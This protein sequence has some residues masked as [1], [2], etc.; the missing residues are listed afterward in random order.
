MAEQLENAKDNQSGKQSDSAEPLRN[1]LNSTQT[2]S[3]NGKQLDSIR[4]GSADATQ[5]L[6]TLDLIQSPQGSDQSKLATGTPD[7]TQENKEP[8]QIARD[9]VEAVKNGA[10]LDNVQKEIGQY[11]QRMMSAG[12]SD[13]EIRKNI[14]NLSNE[15][16]AGNTG[17]TDSNG[18]P[19][20]LSVRLSGDSQNGFTVH[21]LS[22][23]LTKNE[24]ELSRF[25]VSHDGSAQN[26]NDQN[27][28]N[29]EPWQISKDLAEAIRNGQ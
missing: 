16:R 29:K 1:E 17:L 23:E 25:N 9:L 19:M 3:E 5:H 28:E 10:P 22:N 13:F 14:G 26:P 2:G 18:N 6:P 8:W 4:Y 24:K 15:L 21:V 7:K 11:M 12:L 20:D 27:Q